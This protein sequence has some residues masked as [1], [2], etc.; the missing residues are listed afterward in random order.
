MPKVL[1]VYFEQKRKEIV[2]AHAQLM[3]FEQSKWIREVQ[4]FL[5]K[6]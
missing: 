4:S 5:N 3:S 1:D 6:G 2:D